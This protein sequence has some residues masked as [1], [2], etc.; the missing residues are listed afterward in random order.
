MID[1]NTTK[2]YSSM[3]IF[4]TSKEIIEEEE[5]KKAMSVYKKEYWLIFR[6]LVRYRNNSVIIITI[7]P[8]LP[9]IEGPLISTESK[10]IVFYTA[11]PLRCCGYHNY[12]NEII[13]SISLQ[14]NQPIIQEK[15]TIE[16]LIWRPKLSPQPH[17]KG[18]WILVDRYTLR[19]IN[20]QLE[21]STKYEIMVHSGTASVMDDILDDH[22]IYELKTETINLNK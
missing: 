18:S 2:E 1:R 10:G 21:N 4:D 3:V 15:Q 16:N 12:S 17:E 11:E 19:L 13:E 20:V 5:I 7:G 22:Y 6:S 14:F 9:T 8:S